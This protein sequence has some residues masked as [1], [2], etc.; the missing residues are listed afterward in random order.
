MATGFRSGERLTANFALPTVFDMSYLRLTRGWVILASFAA[1]SILLAAFPAIDIQVSGLFFFDGGFQLSN[2]WWAVFLHDSLPWFLGS[3][4]ALVVA[5]YAWNRLSRRNLWGV[6]GKRVF[7]LFIVLA[8][9]AGVIVNVVLKDNFGRARPR[10]IAEF[11]GSKQFTPAFV[12][13]RECDKNC[14]FSSGEGAGGFF[15]LA[16]ALALS[17]RRAA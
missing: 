7:Y 14:S 2:E 16:L 13:S 6:D 17:R 8:L 1:S 11:G 15:A 12:V 3:S 4:M 5:L 10:D 9:G